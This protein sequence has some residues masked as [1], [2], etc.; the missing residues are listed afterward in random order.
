MH[1]VMTIKVAGRKRDHVHTSVLG[2]MATMPVGIYLSFGKG[3]YLP[4]PG[5]I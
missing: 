5:I 3:E 2:N 1:S 4:M